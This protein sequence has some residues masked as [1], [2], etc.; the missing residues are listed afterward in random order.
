MKVKLSYLTLGLG[1][2]FFVSK[3]APN[4]NCKLMA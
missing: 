4:L 2:I 1:I 3:Q